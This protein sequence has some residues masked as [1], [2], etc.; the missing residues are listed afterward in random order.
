MNEVISAVEKEGINAYLRLNEE[1]KLDPKVSKALF[2]HYKAKINGYSLETFS[3]LKL[4]ESSALLNAIQEGRECSHPHY[5]SLAHL[6][7]ELNKNEKEQLVDFI[8]TVMVDPEHYYNASVDIDIKYAPAVNK[9]VLSTIHDYREF[10]VSFCSDK[11]RDTKRK[12]EEYEGFFGD[13]ED[14]INWAKRTYGRKN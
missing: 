1:N 8:K 3:I 10:F 14:E 12:I 5:A 13:I 7:K 6:Y 2:N 9:F 11:D 4:I